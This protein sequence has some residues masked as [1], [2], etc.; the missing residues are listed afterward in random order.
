ME[1][2]SNELG[3]R[4][5]AIHS[6]L[7]SL[8]LT[9]VLIEYPAHLSITYGEREYHA[10]YQ[11]DDEINETGLFEFY[12]FTDGYQGEVFTLDNPDLLS[13]EALAAWLADSVKHLGGEG[14]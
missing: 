10:G 8:G 11:F 12:D 13:L 4:L 7:T 9:D 5:G 14:N 3:N 2:S 6:E 1:L